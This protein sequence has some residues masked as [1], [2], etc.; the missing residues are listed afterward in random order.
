MNSDVKPLLNKGQLLNDSY[1]VGFLLYLSKWVQTYRITDKTGESFVLRIFTSDDDGVNYYHEQI[2]LMTECSP[3]F[4]P[5]LISQS[6][7]AVENQ[8][9]PFFIQKHVSGESLFDRLERLTSLSIATAKQ[10]GVAILKGLESLHSD[11]RSIICNNINCDSILINMAS[12]ETSYH[13]ANFDRAHFSGDS[14]KF[15]INQKE[16]PY[17]ATEAILGKGTQQSDLFSVGVILYRLIY[18]YLPWEII[19]PD[20]NLLPE[21]IQIIASTVRKVGIKTPEI[22]SVSGA[23]FFDILSKALAEDPKQRFQTA[24]EFISALEG[25]TK[26]QPYP[27]KIASPTRASAI[28]GFAAIA[29]MEAL[30]E[31]IKTDVIDALNDREKYQ[32]YGLEIPN[33][34][35]LYGPPGCGKTFFAERMA[36]EIGFNLFQLKPSDIQSQW[37]NA[38][39]GN[40]KK[41]FDNAIK[42][43]PSIVFIDELDAIVP[44]RDNERVN[45]MNTCAVNEFLA[46]MNNCGANGVFIVGATNKPQS[47]DP[48]VLRTGRID[49]KVYIPLPDHDSRMKLFEKML[50]GRPLNADVNIEELASKTDQ[51]VSSDIKFICDE[52]ARAALKKDQ[53]IARKDLLDAIENSGRSIS[54]VEL[55]TYSRL[56]N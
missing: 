20:E 29:G 56:I 27:F 52:A 21:E 26:L 34:M 7:H 24:R 16:I 46:Q 33:G 37:V 55:A 35:L 50:S 30:K 49:K 41:L 10:I 1:E 42:N 53:T 45:H 25:K 14:F 48:A 4:A 31:T 22:S 36:E 32:R 18:G 28:R 47:I 39:Q 17:I 51:Y 13:L 23:N 40:I 6:K 8:S 44:R 38:T 11:S 19:L 12:T 43:A 15:H 2:A 5:V 54:L 9:F 3:I